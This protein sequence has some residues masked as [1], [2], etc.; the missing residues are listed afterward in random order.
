MNSQPASST[1]LELLKKDVSMLSGFMGKLDTAIDKLTD[2]ANS[3]DRVIAVHEEKLEA[4]EKIDQELY[5][6]I[7]ER[8]KE[9]KEQYDLL[10]LRI[11]GMKDDIDTDMKSVIK[12]INENIKEMKEFNSAHH[13]DV[14]ERLTKLEM[15]KW[16]VL[17][18]ATFGGFLLSFIP[19]ILVK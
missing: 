5:A 7:E 15:W 13:D 2:V 8:R 17:G 19:D 6:L 10:H 18:M 16:Y 9:S 1:D 14:S 4:H 3:L 11:S 12:E